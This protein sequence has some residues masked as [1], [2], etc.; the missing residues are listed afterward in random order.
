[1]A[2]A[3]PQQLVQHAPVYLHG[4][5][6]ET[7]PLVK[8]AADQLHTVVAQGLT[9]HYPES[10]R[11]IKNIA[12]HLPRGSFTVVTG[13]VGAGKTTLLRTVLGLLPAERGEIRWNDRLITNP[14]DF[15]IPPR[16]A[17]TPQVPRLYSDTLR[18]NILLG[19][20]EDSVDLSAALRMAVL[21][22]DIAQLEKGLETVV[23]P[24]GVRLSGGQIQRTAAARMFVREPE[25]L[26]FDDL[27]SALDVETEQQLWQ[28]LFSLPA[29][30]TCLVVSH[31]SAALRRADQIIVLADGEV[32]A[33]GTLVTLLQTSP[34]F[35]QLWKEEQSQAED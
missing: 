17:Y 27:S 33:Q 25:L 35:R 32:A 5:Y 9:Y 2:G 20:R 18:D 12:L 14:G 19:L 3:S 15:F 13:R 30:P 10:K 24:R 22:A 7:P 11:G 34:E 21:E 23:G 31:R 26:I 29:R 1:M 6:P 8:S 28:Q 16:C 4:A